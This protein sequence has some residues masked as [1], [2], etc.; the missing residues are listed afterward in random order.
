MLIVC[1]RRAYPA[2]VSS[3]MF[4]SKAR[5]YPN[6]ASF[7]CRL[8]AIH[9]N[10]ILSSKGLPRTNT[11]AYWPTFKLK[12]KSFMILSPVANFIKHF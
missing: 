8:L 7:R 9:T 3:P 4:V 2:Y 5:T 6:E 11:L 10:I 12:G 1:L